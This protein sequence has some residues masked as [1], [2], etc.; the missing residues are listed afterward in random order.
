MEAENY[1]VNLTFFMLPSRENDFLGWLR[2][3]VREFMS[4]GKG[5]DHA[6]S[7]VCELGA[8]EAPENDVQPISVA[9][10]VK[11]PTLEQARAWRDG[12]VAVLS[13]EYERLFAPD[14]MTFVSIFEGIAI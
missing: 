11:F 14:A 13:L 2:P 5:A 4:A 8:G 3:K 7:K 9:Y 1:I 10:Q 12:E 6:L